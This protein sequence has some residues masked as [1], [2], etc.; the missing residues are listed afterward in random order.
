MSNKSKN[1]YS[2]KENQNANSIEE[3]LEVTE[4]VE[5]TK[6]KIVSVTEEPKKKS[7]KKVVVTC[8]ILAIRICPNGPVKGIAKAGTILEVR[9]DAGEWFNTVEGFVSKKFV[10]EV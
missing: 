8:D 9:G 4:T 5:E 6:E 2:P 10:S 3:V 1:H 7:P